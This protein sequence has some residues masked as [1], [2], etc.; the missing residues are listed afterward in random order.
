MQA[1]AAI[2][3]GLRAVLRQGIM[4]RDNTVT[5]AGGKRFVIC[6]CVFMFVNAYRRAVVWRVHASGRLRGF[7]KR[8]RSCGM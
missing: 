3:G 2:F 4:L 1:Q 8:P 5:V 6:G 7:R